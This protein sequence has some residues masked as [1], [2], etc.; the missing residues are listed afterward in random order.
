MLSMRRGAVAVIV[1]LL[2]FSTA[3]CSSTQYSTTDLLGTWWIQQLTIAGEP[4]DFP[5]DSPMGDYPNVDAPGTLEFLEDGRVVGA[6]PCNGVRGRYSFEGRTLTLS[7]VRYQAVECVSEQ[8]MEADALIFSVITDGD[9][10]V[11]F[12]ED[13]LLHLRRGDIQLSLQRP[14]QRG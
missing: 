5:N 13:E 7:E 8:V 12:D 4:Y 10:D 14:P 1:G 6:E 11:T 3:A 2:T 9:V